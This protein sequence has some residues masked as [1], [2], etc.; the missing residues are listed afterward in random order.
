MPASERQSRSNRQLVAPER[1]ARTQPH[2]RSE[3]GTTG[4][5]SPSRISGNAVRAAALD[6]IRRRTLDGTRPITREELANDFLVAGGRFPLIDRGRG[7]RKP[8]GWRAALSIATPVP[9]S[10][11]GQY[12][13]DIGPDGLTSRADAACMVCGTR[14]KPL[15]RAGISSQRRSDDCTSRYS[16]AKSCWRMTRS[17]R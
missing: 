7:I 14:T 3:P 6:W 4:Q 5:L 10:G 2:C 1:G 15:Q 16:Q 17:H 9:K 11:V 12:E 8:L 13:D